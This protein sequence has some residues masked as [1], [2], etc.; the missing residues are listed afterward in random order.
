MSTSTPPYTTGSVTSADGTT[1]GYRQMGSGPG[2]IL[3]SGGY[4]AAQH[5]MQLAGALSDAFTVYVPD[6]RG[7]GLSGPPGNRY[8]MARECEDVDALLTK[9]GA[10]FVWGHS[11]GALI[12]LQAAIT[13][14]SI[15]KVAVYEPPLSRHGSISTSWIP[16][17]DREVAQG[18]LASALVTFAKE[19]NLVPAFV[20][21]WLLVPLVA[22]YLRRERRRVKPPDVPMEALIPLQR[23]DGQLVKEMDSSLES[24]AGMRA[25]V[26]LMGGQKSPAFLREILDA[27][28]QTLPHA[29]RIEFRG[30]GHGAPADRA[31]PERVGEELRAFFAGSD[32]FLD[33]E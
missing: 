29:Q 26:L 20:P 33:G 30:V 31:A 1:V 12:A 2:V 15:R 16:R 19:D 32:G 5:Y 13:L 18:K 27:L 11:S 22:L 6:R 9:T 7:R 10:H 14:P 23:F 4:L 3:L 17:F 8:S 28:Q 24:F 21:R 25:D